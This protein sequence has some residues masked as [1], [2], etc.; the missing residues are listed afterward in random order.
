MVE[1]KQRQSGGAQEEAEAEREKVRAS[2]SFSTAT[3]LDH[4][5]LIVYISTGLDQSGLRGAPTDPQGR[6]LR[7]VGKSKA[8]GLVL[9]S[10]PEGSHPKHLQETKASPTVTRMTESLR[11][12]RN[13]SFHLLKLTA[14]DCTRL[15]L[16][17]SFKLSTVTPANSCVIPF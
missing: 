11:R 9:D 1:D 16:I 13:S 2:L 4:Q 10:P 8:A 14:A 5:C 15:S 12:P 3:Q 7:C 6:L 17:I